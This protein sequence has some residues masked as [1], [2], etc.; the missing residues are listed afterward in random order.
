MVLHALSLQMHQFR[1]FVFSVG[2]FGDAARLFCWDHSGAVVSGPIIYSESGNRQLPEF[3]YRFNVTDR[4]Q[5]GWNPTVSGVILADTAGFAHAIRT[6]VNGGKSKLLEELL[7]SVGDEAM[8]PRR[9]VDVIHPS[10]RQRSYIIGHSVVTPK[11]PMES[12]PS[13]LWLWRGGPGIWCS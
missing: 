1:A 6:V 2:I 7:E 5:W 11:T 8:D 3:F 13:A 12:A 10:G 9:K 4:V